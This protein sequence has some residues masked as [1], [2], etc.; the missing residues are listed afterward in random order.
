VSAAAFVIVFEK[1]ASLDPPTGIYP[2]I[3]PDVSVTVH[4]STFAACVVIVARS[5]CEASPFATVQ[6]GAVR[7][8]VHEAEVST[9]AAVPSTDV[10]ATLVAETAVNAIPIDDEIDEDSV[11][12]PVAVIVTDSLVVAELSTRK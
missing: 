1:I 3:R 4:D 2:V 12:D 10:N 5:V 9:P 8:A 7:D 6:A 11:P